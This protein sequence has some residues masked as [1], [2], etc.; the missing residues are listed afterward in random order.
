[1]S[2]KCHINV[3]H[4]H[5][6]CRQVVEVY[7][8]LIPR[9]SVEEGISSGIISN[10][11]AVQMQFHAGKGRNSII[12]IEH[13]L[14][15]SG[16][17]IDVVI[18]NPDG[19]CFDAQIRDIG[20][21]NLPE[22]SVRTTDHGSGNGGNQSNRIGAEGEQCAHIQRQISSKVF[23]QIAGSNFD[24]H[25]AVRADDISNPDTVNAFTP[26]HR[27]VGSEVHDIHRSAEGAAVFEDFRV[28]GDSLCIGNQIDGSGH[29]IGRHHGFEYCNPG[30][31][32]RGNGRTD[33]V[34]SGN[35][36]IHASRDIDRYFVDILFVFS[37]D[38]YFDLGVYTLSGN[39]FHHGF[40]PGAIS[41]LSKILGVADQRN[42]GTMVG[43]FHKLVCRNAVTNFV[44]KSDNDVLRSNAGVAQGN[45]SGNVSSPHSFGFK[46]ADVAVGYSVA[47]ADATNK[48]IQI[49]DGDLRFDVCICVI[50]FISEEHCDVDVFTGYHIVVGN[51]RFTSNHHSVKNELRS[52]TVDHDQ[53]SAVEIGVDPGGSEGLVFG[54]G[55]IVGY[56][57]GNPVFQTKGC[58][59]GIGIDL[60]V[61]EQVPSVGV[62]GVDLSEGMP[63]YVR[64]VSLG[65]IIDLYQDGSDGAYT[66]CTSGV[67]HNLEAQVFTGSY[68]GA[69][70]R[71]QFI[72]GKL[73]IS[74]DGLCHSVVTTGIKADGDDGG[75]SYIEVGM[76]RGIG[77]AG[78]VLVAGKVFH[79]L[80]LDIQDG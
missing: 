49:I 10:H 79:L 75:V 27:S 64:I 71:I 16:L 43:D 54:G 58:G 32:F 46:I 38:I 48:A 44:G 56:E 47:G 72:T 18:V 37:I 9:S 20:S 60:Q 24:H 78:I 22:G 29:H 5:I 21:S 77:S 61:I 70:F 35:S 40:L 6:H 53:L 13:F 23:T 66:G 15:E 52:A 26:Y 30:A 80:Q 19:R 63:V 31:G 34:S 1:M 14:Y 25:V 33:G 65:G 76:H 39:G 68:I 12:N 50:R 4:T 74:N 57:I 73:L 69:G 42:D 8:D 36:D 17:T 3:V 67:Q 41:E 11:R 28:V 51:R 7:S 59:S 45:Q 55:I 2:V 62:R